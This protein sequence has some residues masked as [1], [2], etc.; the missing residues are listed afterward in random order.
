MISAP[1]VSISPS[2]FITRNVGIIVSWNGITIVASISP[3]TSFDPAN[4]IRAN[5]YPPSEP[6]T[7]LAVTATADTMNEFR[8]QRGNNAFPST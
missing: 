7:R 6:R 8:N 3:S 5:A 4:R 2:S 1:R